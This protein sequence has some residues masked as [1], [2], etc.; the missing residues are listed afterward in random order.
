[1]VGKGGRWRKG[2]GE[3]RDGGEGEE[4][5]EGKEEEL[6]N[7]RGNREGVWERERNRIM[8]KDKREGKGLNLPKT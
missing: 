3:G 4:W 6:R 1:M 5:E 2:K 8:K 7:V